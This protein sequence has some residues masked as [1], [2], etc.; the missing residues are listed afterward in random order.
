MRQ[1]NIDFKETYIPIIIDSDNKKYYPLRY[2]FEKILKKSKG[3]LYNKN[4]QNLFVMLDIQYK[5]NVEKSKCVDEE[6]LVLILMSSGGFDKSP[7]GIIERYKSF[8]ELLESKQ[9]YVLIDIL[10]KRKNEIIDDELAFIKGRFGKDIHDMYKS[11]DT[12]SI[13]NH[14]YRNKD[15]MRFPKIIRKKECLLEIISDK[16]NKCD[17]TKDEIA[18]NDLEKRYSLPNGIIV[19]EEIYIHLFGEDFKLYPWEYKNYQNYSLTKSDARTILNN[20]FFKVGI[21]KNNI[22]AI[23]EIGWYEFLRGARLEKFVEVNYEDRYTFILECLGYDFPVY[24]FKHVGGK[25]WKNKRN[26]AKAIRQLIDELGIDID[27]IPMYITNNIVQKQS[28]TMYGLL[29]KHYE[30]NIYKFIDEAYPNKFEKTD[31]YVTNLKNKFDSVEESL[32]DNK[33]REY[34]DMVIYN[35][36][37]TENTI[38]IKNMT[39]DWF[40]AINGTLYIVEYFGL[41]VPAQKSSSRVSDYIQRTDKKIE[42]YEMVKNYKKIYIYPQDLEDRFKGFHKKIQKAIGI[43][44]SA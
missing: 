20:Y 16:Y 32:V 34:F 18:I 26:R 19:S 39:P 15:S 8:V 30:G 42:K 25:H 24:R 3:V 2:I 31:F 44:K 40:V 22:E 23:C 37:Y 38:K 5:C 29:I 10:D 11:K 33:L 36:R 27:K 7:F 28:R 17:F 21:D 43:E 35:E 9:K 6:S 1:A 41:Y 14:Y 13:Y 4:Y 12:M